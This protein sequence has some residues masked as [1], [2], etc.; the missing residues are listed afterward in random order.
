MRSLVKFLGIAAVAFFACVAAIDPASADGCNQ[1]CGTSFNQ[2]IVQG[3]GCCWDDGTSS[4]P[5]GDGHCTPAICGG[6]CLE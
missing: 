3:S 1:D 2:C 6:V 5:M 4:D